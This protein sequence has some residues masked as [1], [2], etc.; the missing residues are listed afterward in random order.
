M[1][2]IKCILKKSIWLLAVVSAMVFAGCQDEDDQQNS[3]NNNDSTTDYPA[4]ADVIHNAV[5]DID[6]NTYDAVR[7]G[8]QIW[9]AS[10]L[11]T[12]HYANGEIIPEYDPNIQN[13]FWDEVDHDEG[14]W[15]EGYWN[16][17]QNPWRI[18]SSPNIADYGYLY[19]HD[20]VMHGAS[21]SNTVPSGVQGICPNGWHVPSRAEWERLTNYMGT[22]IE[23]CCSEERLAIAKALSSTKW[24][25]NETLSLNPYC[26]CMPCYQP[27]ITNNASGFSALPSG[28]FGYYPDNSIDECLRNF[29]STA[30]YHTSL[31]FERN[32]SQHKMRCKLIELDDGFS[33]LDSWDYNC[34][35]GGFSVRC[36]KD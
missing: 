18:A 26:S 35:D 36:V 17:H 34:T 30:Y 3:N 10:N 7:I 22:Q 23:Y 19:N 11:R 6:G 9:M 31:R 28:Y 16:S 20:A 29:G 5:T 15:N 12:T 2:E 24:P 32:E 25:K 13:D 8:D 14:Y 33:H 27:E 1:K 21:S 4:T